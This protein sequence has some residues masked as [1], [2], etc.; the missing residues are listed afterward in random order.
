MLSFHPYYHPNV[1][2]V[3]NNWIC[4]GLPAQRAAKTVQSSKKRLVRRFALKNRQLS[5]RRLAG[6][7]SDVLGHSISARSV[8]RS[9][10]KFCLW[11]RIMAKVR[12]L[13]N[14]QKFKRLAWAR[15]VFNWPIAQWSR[16]VFRDEKIFRV[17]SNR[18]GC[19][20]TKFSTEKY[21]EYFTSVSSKFGP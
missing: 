16:V 1:L 9:L 10:R 20:V 2:P 12:F 15:K 3:Q 6:S 4:F 7:T 8:G 13:T 14:K 5:T 19:F 18:H 17:S 11:R 21:S